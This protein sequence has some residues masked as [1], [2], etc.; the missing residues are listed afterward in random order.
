MTRVF[1]CNGKNGICCDNDKDCAGCEHYDNGGGRYVQPNEVDA[2][3]GANA[4]LRGL[5]AK[6]EEENRL[7][8]NELCLKCGLYEQAHNGACN[9]CR[10]H[11]EG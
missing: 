7:L 3:D 8:R 10:W 5:V 11:K 9:G 6:L 1:F 2:L 4:A